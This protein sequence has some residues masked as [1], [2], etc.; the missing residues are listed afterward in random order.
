LGHL[1]R[2][3]N[4]ECMRLELSRAAGSAPAPSRATCH[5]G[6]ETDARLR[7]WTTYFEHERDHEY[8][9]PGGAF[10][11]LD[12]AQVGRT[13]ETGEIVR[14]CI[15]PPG[16]GDRRS[17]ALSRVAR[18]EGVVFPLQHHFHPNV[19]TKMNMTPMR[20]VRQLFQALDLCEKCSGTYGG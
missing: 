12:H 20:P 8:A 3:P 5:Y 13:H 7:V 6:H 1:K 19:Y 16:F 14:W 10:R 15:F 11:V 4:T 2:L 18:N 9:R 17:S